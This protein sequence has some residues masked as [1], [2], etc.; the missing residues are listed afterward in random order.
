MRLLS[1]F[2]F[3]VFLK[4]GLLATSRRVLYIV[5]LAFIMLIR[6]V[7]VLPF[8]YARFWCDLCKCL[9]LC[10]VVLRL[11]LA[12][13]LSRGELSSEKRWGLKSHDSLPSDRI[14]LYACCVSKFLSGCLLVRILSWR[15]SKLSL[16]LASFLCEGSGTFIGR[17]ES[18]GLLLVTGFFAMNSSS[19]Q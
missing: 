13:G 6:S 7:F 8:I 1:F 10:I 4:E 14:F 17:G 18:T 9:T 15:R 11:L 5:R 3:I 19:G 16:L 12:K 2:Y